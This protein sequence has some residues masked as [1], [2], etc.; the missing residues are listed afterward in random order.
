[1]T[2]RIS[3]CLSYWNLWLKF[4]RS[5]EK[6]ISCSQSLTKQ[7]WPKTNWKVSAENYNV[8]AN[9]LRCLVRILYHIRIYPS[10]M[11]K[12]FLSFNSGIHRGFVGAV[13]NFWSC[14]YVGHIISSSVIC[15]EVQHGSIN[16]LIHEITLAQTQQVLQVMALIDSPAF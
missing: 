1:M 11:Y 7:V 2:L 3:G 8:T 14:C 5:H 9:L 16:M 15:Q 6:E 4:Y 12:V 13:S 10:N